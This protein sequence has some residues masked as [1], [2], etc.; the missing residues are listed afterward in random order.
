M[1]SAVVEQS[2][3]EE[4]GIKEVSRVY[5]ITYSQAESTKVSSRQR[6]AEIVSSSIKQEEFI[7][8]WPLNFEDQDDGCR[9]GS[10]FIHD[11][12][13]MSISRIVM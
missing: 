1:D 10:L 5:L 12:E 8:T 3:Q 11:T 6:F 2:S 9:F 7:S 13:L 4:L